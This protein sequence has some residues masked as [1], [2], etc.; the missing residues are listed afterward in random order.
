MEFIYPCRKNI[1]EQHN[2][3]AG[4]YF[5]G[6]FVKF[7]VYAVVVVLLNVAGLT[8]FFRYD[9]TRNQMYSISKASQSVVETLSEP[10]SIKVFFSKNLPAP[11]NNTERYL[12]DLLEEYGNYANRFFNYRFYDVTAESG[13]ITP[14]A[15]ENQELAKNYGIMPVQIQAVEKDEVKFLKAYMGL[16]II[17]GD[18]IERIPTITST[19]GMEYRL[20]T[21][22]RKLNNKVSALVGLKEN[23]QVRLLLSSSL[24]PVAPLLNLD[25]L[26]KLPK[27]IGEAVTKLNEKTYGKLVFQHLDPADDTRGLAEE[28][29]KHNIITL[30]WPNLPDKKIDGGS[31]SI[32]LVMAYGKNSVS[33]P[34]LQVIR[35]PIIGT[36]YEMMDDERIPEVIEASIES[37]I[38]IHENIG[39]LAEFESIPIAPE[40]PQQAMMQENPESAGTLYELLSKNYSV[41]NITLSEK[42]NL[43]GIKCMIIAGPVEPLSDYDLFRIDQ[44]LMKGNNLAIFLDSFKEIMPQNQQGLRLNN[45]GPVFVP[46][47]TGIEKLLEHYGLRI[48]PSYVLDENCF[49]QQLPAQLGGGERPIYFAPLIK[50]SHINAQL[51]VIKSIKGMVA[52]KMS[53]L[54]LIESRI[55][56]QQIKPH[57]LFSSSEDSWEMKGRIN[58][59]PML[60]T[61]PQSGDEK[62]S[63]PLAYLL[64]GEFESY[65]NGKP[66]PE[67]KSQENED[68]AE[69]SMA[70]GEE[71]QSGQPASVLPE[72]ESEGVFIPQ[73][74]PGRILLIGSAE[75]IKNNIMDK[76]GRSPND[77]FILNL[78]DYL[79]GNEDIAI[80]RSKEQ[81][82]NPLD[83]MGAGTKTFVK[84][85]NIIGLPVFVILFGLL[86]WFRRHA[87]KNRIQMI[88]K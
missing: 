44:F 62:R 71:Q 12:Q 64:E 39:V 20:T 8:L 42:G 32:G 59:N 6:R 50:S 75:I 7:I 9:L 10:L 84:S 85:F 53:P 40:P 15:K 74:K 16:V 88:F 36:Q 23:I 79:N 19:D 65:F 67:K 2:M 46:V 14:E 72:I 30:K 73:G 5:P 83:D 43:A 34:L 29:R 58:L 21:A 80:M 37:L 13:D 31:G 51:D 11:H 38:D 54:S 77:M 27:T 24:E 28:I 57:L 55:K 76:D 81:R 3:I 4:K 25:R 1:K 49:K 66:I 86:V 61:P 60:I 63:Y 45:Q 70:V 35:L 26:S 56:A 82:F 47:Q 78:L 48:S 33:I 87:R 41:K 18:I 22:I 17:H 69:E 68:A 52:V